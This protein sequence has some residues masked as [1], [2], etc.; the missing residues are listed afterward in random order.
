[1]DAW[2]LFMSLDARLWVKVAFSLYVDE[3]NC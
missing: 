2:T 3:L 1:M